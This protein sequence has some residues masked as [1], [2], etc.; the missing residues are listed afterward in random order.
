VKARLTAISFGL[1]AVAAVFL[2]VWPVYSGFDGRRTTHSTLLEV[3]G[4]R[5]VIPVMFPVL[6]AFTAVL[7]RKEAV[8]IVATIIMWLFTIISGFSIGLFYLEPR[9]YAWFLV[10]HRQLH[11]FHLLPFVH[12]RRLR[13][14]AISMRPRESVGHGLSIF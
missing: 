3:N 12:D 9:G 2:M 4:A 13:R 6:V 7:F 10:C 8:R 1:A 11:W 14:L 5:V